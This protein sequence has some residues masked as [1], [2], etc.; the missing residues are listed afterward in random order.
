MKKEI[1]IKG[2]HCASCAVV[3]EKGLNKIE[4]VKANVNF[5]SESAQ[6][7]LSSMQKMEQVNN[8]I[9]SLGYEVISDKENEEKSKKKALDK[10]KK[11]VILTFILAIPLGVIAMGPMLGLVLPSMFDSVWIQLI[12]ASIIVLI[13]YNFYIN[14]FNAIIKARSANMDTLVS[15]GTGAAY[16]YSIVNLL[17]GNTMDLYFET[18]GLLLAFILLG[19]YFEAVAKHRT[20]SAIRKLL[21]LRPKKATIIRNGK[22][23]M[24]GVDE[25]VKGD[26]VIVKPGQKVPVDGIIISGSSTIDESMI[27]GESL[28][29]EKKKGDEVVGGTINKSGS[30]KFKAVKVGSGTFLSQVVKMVSEAQMSKA[31][32]QRLADKISSIFVPLVVSVALFAGIVWLLSGQ[33]FY[34]ATKIFITVVII[35]CPC[36]LG[37]ATPTAIMVGTGK[38]AEN[39]IL[40]KNVEAL[41]KINKTK[42]VVFDKTGTLTKGEPLVQKIIGFNGLKE[43]DVLRITGGAEAQ[44]EHPLA[45]AVMKELKEKKIHLAKVSKF[46]NVSG[47]GVT[48][49]YNSKKL[50]VGNESFMKEY[51][52]KIEEAEEYIKEY[53]SK[54]MTVILTGLDKELIG[55]VAIN[56]ELKPTSKEAIRELQKQ[57]YIVYMITGDNKATAENIAEQ[58]GVENVFANV[59]P[60][61][62]AKKVKQLQKIGGVIMVGDGVN[63]AVALTQA[64]VGIALGSGTDV[65]IESGDI[66]IVKNDVMDVSRAINLGRAT[67]NKIK[68]NLFW[69]FFYNSAGIPIAAGVLYPFFGLLLNP[70]IAGLAMSFSSVSVVTNSL[71]LRAKKL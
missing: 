37:L 5:A 4:G 51:S 39:G 31:P 66:V 46:N 1:K 35:S 3:I 32:V 7:E 44:S 68:Q 9:K 20:G 18:T 63:D 64:D 12:L 30:F 65:A 57:G 10:M 52:V 70:I 24:V 15:I 19:E 22:E 33:S 43:S 40:F 27:T 17:L 69:A 36:A 21:E 45:Q 67:F 58:L 62:K 71:L 29:V 28:P 38:G 23:V 50:I 2:M 42:Y 49:D 61:D 34:F 25:I 56:D 8:V 59:L 16:I 6:V 41:E 11:R 54:G 48:A 60:G 14:G 55:L 47:S 13:N 26:V 53:Q